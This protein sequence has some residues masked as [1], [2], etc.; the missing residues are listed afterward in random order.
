MDEIKTREV[1]IKRTK[2]KEKGRGN[3]EGKEGKIKEWRH[4]C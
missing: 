4:T 1:G 3:K 2:E